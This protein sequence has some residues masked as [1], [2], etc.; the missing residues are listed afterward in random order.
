MF[1]SKHHDGFANWPSTYN[2]GWN[3]ADIG[4]HRDVVGDLKKAFKAIVPGIKFGLYYSLYEWFHPLYQADK[5]N[6]YTSR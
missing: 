6:Q 2:Y 3:S 1:T 5:E 4:A